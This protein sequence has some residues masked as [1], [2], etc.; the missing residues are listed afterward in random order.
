M[1]TSFAAVGLAVLVL[2]GCQ[3]AEAKGAD[4]A[5]FVGA[6]LRAASG[7]DELRGWSFLDSKMQSAMFGNDVEAYVAAVWA[8]DWSDLAWEV[9]GTAPEDSFV[10]VHL[11]LTA[12]DYPAV[13]I[14]PRGNFTLA[15]G[16]GDLRTFSVRFGMFGSRTLFASGG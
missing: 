10:F 15:G 16:D 9:A 13:L 14:E 1:R 11:R 4:A 6:Y 5:D 12:G 8:S 3:S 7:G 2:V